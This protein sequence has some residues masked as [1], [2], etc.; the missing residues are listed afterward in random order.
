[1]PF[2]P[3]EIYCMLSDGASDLLEIFGVRRQENFGQ[4]V[5]WFKKLACQPER[6]DDYSVVCIE[7]VEKNTKISICNIQNP[8]ELAQAQVMI[9]EFL[10]QH[11]P[12]CVVL[13]EVAINEA[14]NN[15]LVAS[16]RIQVKLKRT[17]SRIVVRV[18]DNGTG[19][20]TKQVNALG[21]KDVDNEFEQLGL[22]ERGRGIMMMKMFCDQIIYNALGNE[23][24]LMK[25]I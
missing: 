20:S 15:G 18:K 14:V 21:V 11:A 6:M 3:G 1:M 23:V 8:A 25:K 16:E 10:A 12:T 9:A 7:I 22:S 2:K 4:Y 24:L 19:F 5:N 17:G 13:F